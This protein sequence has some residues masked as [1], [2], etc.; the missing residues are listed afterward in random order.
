MELEGTLEN[1]PVFAEE[2]NLPPGHTLCRGRNRKSLTVQRSF[3][4]ILFFAV[5]QLLHGKVCVRLGRICCSNSSLP[6]EREKR[7]LWLLPINL[8]HSTPCPKLSLSDNGVGC[9][10]MT[11]IFKLACYC[12]Y[13][14]IIVLSQ[15]PMKQT[16][17]CRSLLGKFIRECKGKDCAVG[18]FKLNEVT[19]KA[20][21]LMWAL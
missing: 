2:A 17:A 4:N 11:M 6:Q 18:G 13:E 14:C 9:Q 8:I 3:N 21:P 7:L 20:P 12:V 1:S 16:C 15:M 5:D 10:K 19:T